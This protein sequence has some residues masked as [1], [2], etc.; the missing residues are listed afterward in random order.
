MKLI[1]SIIKIQNPYQVNL[2]TLIT[3]KPT[4]IKFNNPHKRKLL[5]HKQ[6]LSPWLNKFF[7]R[8]DEIN[9]KPAKTLINRIAW[10][11]P[12]LMA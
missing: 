2:K 11:Y 10:Q 1:S 4:L 5:P 6:N 7:P 8:K 3:K 9:V 12:R